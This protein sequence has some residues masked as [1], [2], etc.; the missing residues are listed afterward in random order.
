MQ[1]FEIIE[2][3]SLEIHCDGADGAGA[4]LGHP[5]VFLHID[6]DKGAI[7]CP[8]CSRQYVLAAFGGKRAGGH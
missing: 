6:P 8:Y 4:S 3:N 5:R 2:T 1:P 7:V